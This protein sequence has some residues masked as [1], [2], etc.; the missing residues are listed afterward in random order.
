MNKKKGP[1]LALSFYNFG[2]V[3]LI[4]GKTDVAI[5]CFKSALG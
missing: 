5:R 2:I 1:K 4:L 3:K